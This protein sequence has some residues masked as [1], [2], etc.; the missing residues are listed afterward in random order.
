VDAYA[1]FLNSQQSIQAFRQDY[2][3]TLKLVKELGAQE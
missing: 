1:H 2:E 3:V